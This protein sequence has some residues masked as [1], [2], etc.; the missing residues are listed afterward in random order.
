MTI[1]GAGKRWL[2]DVALD[3]GS[4][5][6][7]FTQWLGYTGDGRLFVGLGGAGMI[8][9]KDG[10]TAHLSLGNHHVCDITFRKVTP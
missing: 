10:E 9:I 2:F 5:E 7:V 1:T 6:V 4:S 3:S 8:A